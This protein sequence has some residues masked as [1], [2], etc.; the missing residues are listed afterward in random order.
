[1]RDHNN[2]DVA[3][4]LYPKDIIDGIV[5][6]DGAYTTRTLRKLDKF[7]NVYCNDNLKGS[8]SFELKFDNEIKKSIALQIITSAIKYYKTVYSRCRV[9]FKYQNITEDTAENR[10]IMFRSLDSF[11]SSRRMLDYGVPSNLCLNNGPGTL[12][13]KRV[14]KQASYE[15]YVNV[16]N[17]VDKSYIIQ[18]ANDSRMWPV[19]L[20][21]PVFN[22]K[23][24]GGIYV[25]YRNTKN[26]V[27]PEFGLLSVVDRPGDIETFN[28][29]FY[30]YCKDL[31]ICFYFNETFTDIEKAVMKG[32]L[33]PNEPPV[34]YEELRPVYTSKYA[35]VVRYKPRI[36]HNDAFVI[37]VKTDEDSVKFKTIDF[38][39][40]VPNFWIKPISGENYTLI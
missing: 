37:S 16:I 27:T 11:I 38:Y 13:M 23:G 5:A 9:S 40:K 32:R 15:A 24:D 19:Y 33:Y 35:K 39:N 36:G 21:T 8:F 3:S 22:K 20:D 14:V 30:E 4:D 7:L 17:K 29:I 1:M 26:I 31:R 12:T 28:S 18:E 34:F 6:K 25:F 10:M 2:P